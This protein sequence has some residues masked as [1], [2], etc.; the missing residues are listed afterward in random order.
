VLLSV[1]LAGTDT[2]L[3]GRLLLVVLLGALGMIALAVLGV[4]HSMR[5]TGLI[6]RLADT[7]AQIR[8]R[9]TVL[10]VAALALAAQALG[11]RRSSAPSSR[12]PGAR[13]TPIPAAVSM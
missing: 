1:G 10:L 11:S 2:P 12:V 8:V 6:A 7:S 4:E 13:S 3:A 9:L 5:L